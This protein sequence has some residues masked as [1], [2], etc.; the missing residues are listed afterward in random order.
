MNDW[1]EKANDIMKGDGLIRYTQGEVEECLREA[2]AT[3]EKAEGQAAIDA[4]NHKTCAQI[5]AVLNAEFATLRAW[6]KQQPCED[7]EIVHGLRP[8]PCGKC[9]PC[10]EKARKG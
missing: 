10:V 1:R 7:V 6:V 8:K 2:L 9:L 5:V 3:L 4:G